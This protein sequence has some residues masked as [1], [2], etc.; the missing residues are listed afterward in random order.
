MII[1]KAVYIHN[2]V[3]IKIDI[4]LLK[5]KYITLKIIKH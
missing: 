5:K 1:Q 4:I 2:Q 3:E